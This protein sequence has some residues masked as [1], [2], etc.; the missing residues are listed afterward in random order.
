ML[1]RLI[2]GH[3]ET[4][5]GTVYGTIVV[6]SMLVAGARD[7]GSDPWRLVVIVTAGATVLWAA[8]VY[9]HGL[10]ESVKAD[11]RLTLDQ[12]LTLA[13]REGAILFAAVLPITAIALGALSVLSVELAL[14]LAVGIGVATLAIQAVRYARLEQLGPAGAAAVIALNVSLGLVFVGLKALFA[15]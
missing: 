14:W 10:G 2:H 6:L 15:H 9:A 5:S 8:H 1:R 4:I 11:R 12:L 3:V 7:Y 13:V